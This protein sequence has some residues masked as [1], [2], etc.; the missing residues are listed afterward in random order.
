[1]NLFGRGWF[2]DVTSGI[3][4]YAFLNL[5]CQCLWLKTTAIHNA[6]ERNS[7]TMQNAFNLFIPF[8]PFPLIVRLVIKLNGKQ[9]AKLFFVARYKIH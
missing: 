9:R 5:C 7:C 4:I 2:C 8:N 3:L 6:D 1:M